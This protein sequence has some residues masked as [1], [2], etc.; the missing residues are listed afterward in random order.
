MAA[1]GNPCGRTCGR[2]NAMSGE[3]R[4]GSEGESRTGPEAECGMP[5]EATPIAV[6]ADGDGGAETLAPPEDHPEAQGSAEIGSESP[7]GEPSLRDVYELLRSHAARAGRLR[8]QDDE[9]LKDGMQRLEGLAREMGEHGERSVRLLTELSGKSAEDRDALKAGVG[10]CE[11]GIKILGRSLERWSAARR[12]RWRRL[13][14]LALAAALPALL[15][16]GM[17]MQKEFEIVPPHD[18]TGGWRGHIWENYGR[19]ISDCA[20]AARRTGKPVKCSFTVHEP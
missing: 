2:M 17:L 1:A 13:P 3:D 15:L 14:E 5:E 4:R 9:R 19:T 10:R 12:R 18:P 16:L 7:T 20:V 11:E 6:E 8:E